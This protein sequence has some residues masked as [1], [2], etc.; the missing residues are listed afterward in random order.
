VT[1]TYI[2]YCPDCG[3]E[4]QPHMTACLDC[5]TALQ[6]KLDGAET[7]E[8]DAPP[9]MVPEPSLPPGDY[10]RVAHGLTAQAVEP[11]VRLFVAA[12][13]PVKVES[14]GYGLT[15]SARSEDRPAVVEILEREGVIPRQSDAPGVAA[16]G[17]PC[18]AC[19]THINPGTV[20]CL[21]CGLLLG[22]FCECGEG[23][24]P[25]DDVCAACGRRLD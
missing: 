21:E 7:P 18:P 5:G 13:I 20:E 14:I 3:E 6:E 11:V 25:G 9:E 23:L 8:L 4:Y 16:D 22:A 19:G 10:L 2:R 12:R 24:S 1:N 17:G 15:L